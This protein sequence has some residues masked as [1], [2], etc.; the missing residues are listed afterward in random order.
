MAKS[1][2]SR[3]VSAQFTE[4]RTEL[5]VLPAWQ[6]VQQALDDV[7]WDWGP[8]DGEEWSVVTS[9]TAALGWVTSLLLAVLAEVVAVVAV[10]ACYAAATH[11]PVLT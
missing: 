6:D 2:A 10:V 9:C 7:D 5:L 3:E 8:E 1:N 4:L 11:C